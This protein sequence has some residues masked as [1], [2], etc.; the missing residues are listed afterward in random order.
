VS[1]A[2]LHVG[3]E[4]WVVMREHY[5]GRRADTF[6]ADRRRVISSDTGT[7]CL[8][9]RGGAWPYLEFWRAEEVYPTRAAAEA[10]ARRRQEEG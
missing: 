4:V 10:E 6:A 9:G 7:A 8:T 5:A 2:D 1:P 3:R